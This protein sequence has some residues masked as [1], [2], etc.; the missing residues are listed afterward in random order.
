M[1]TATSPFRALAAMVLVIS[2]AAVPALADTNRIV[3]RVNDRIATLYDYENARRQLIED[4]RRSDLSPELLQERLADV[5]VGVMSDLLEE[6][7][8]LSRADQIE[9][10]PSRGEVSE[11]VQRAKDSAGVKTEEDFAKGLAAAGFTVETFRAH[12]E[13]NLAMNSVMGQEVRPRVALNEE[14]LRRYYQTHLE[15][16][17]V[18]ARLKV[19]E[20]VVLDTATRDAESR[21]AIAEDIRKLLIAGGAAPDA[22]ADYVEK[23]LTTGWVDIGWVEAGDLDPAIEE[24]IWHLGSGEFSPA[25]SARGGLHLCQ[26][27][28]REEATIQE[29]AAVADQIQQQ[30]TNR[31]FAAEIGEYL[32]ELERNAYVIIKPPPEAAA[33]RSVLERRREEGLEFDERETALSGAAEAHLEVEEE[34]GDGPR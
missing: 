25:V 29:F 8:L 17:R 34:S 3:L 7:L 20:I 9:V 16:F 6:M 32:A 14:D 4:L 12:I 15:E 23:G 30:E 13:K 1:A 26:I 5:G 2:L 24:A 19:R 27:V 28:E 11:A 33:F 18:P 31:R 21:A 10:V 22:V